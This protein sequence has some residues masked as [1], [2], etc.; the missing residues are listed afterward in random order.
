M[1]TIPDRCTPS[2]CPGFTTLN[3]DR[4]SIGAGNTFGGIDNLTKIQGRNV[5]KA[6]V[7]IRRIQMNQGRGPSGTISYASASALESNEVNTAKYTEAEPINGLRKFTYFG[8]IQ[9]EF[10]WTPELTLNL[11]ARYSF[12]NIFHDVYGR[13]NPFDFATCGVGGYCGVGASFGSADLP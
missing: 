9:D 7:E 8:Y 6:G 3:N 2:P 4:V 10:K 12:F 5:I 11:G 1:P 13:P